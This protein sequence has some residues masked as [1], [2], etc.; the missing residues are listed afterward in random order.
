MRASIE[1]G[2]SQDM[3]DPRKRDLVICR[4]QEPGGGNIRWM[5]SPFNCDTEDLY[6]IMNSEKNED[7]LVHLQYRDNDVLF[8]TFSMPH[9]MSSHGTG[10]AQSAS[11]GNNSPALPTSNRDSRPNTGSLSTSKKRVRKPKTKLNIQRNRKRYRERVKNQANETKERYAKVAEE[12]ARLKLE[13]EQLHCERTML[14]SMCKYSESAVNLV[15]SAAASISTL[16][17]DSAWQLKVAAQAKMMAAYGDII[18]TLYSKC[19]RPT[20]DQLRAMFAHGA[21]KIKSIHKKSFLDRLCQM[22]TEWQ[23]SSP[24]GREVLERK[25][26]YAFETRARIAKIVSREQP[27]MIE[28][29]FD[30][31]NK[32]IEA[33]Q[34]EPQDVSAI[35][36]RRTLLDNEELV[37][38]TVLTEE[39]RIA[40]SRHW[41]VYL[42]HDEFSR[43]RIKE[44]STTVEQSLTANQTGARPSHQPV[45]SLA[46]VAR[47]HLSLLKTSASLEELSNEELIARINLAVDSVAVLRPLQLAYVMISTL[48]HADT[49]CDVVSMYKSLLRLEGADFV[50]KYDYEVAS[51]VCDCSPTSTA[52]PAIE[53]A[54]LNHHSD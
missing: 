13:Q 38:A 31:S 33:T 1:T 37:V 27:A 14:E 34:L 26:S 44:S 10:T 49:I 54:P 47:S 22:I 50:L 28:T 20:D 48:P 53:R 42:A 17:T 3:I 8:D 30:F 23:T 19:L 35:L 51:D 25:L 36:A 39:Q 7:L 46:Q 15:R 29:I 6:H 11:K 18:D 52:A 5:Q 12:I 45:G 40:L 43:V 16:A 2:V 9:P 41:K 21:V 32:L 4:G 24:A